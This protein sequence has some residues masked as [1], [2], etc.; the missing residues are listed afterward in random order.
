MKNVRELRTEDKTQWSKTKKDL[1]QLSVMYS[2]YNIQYVCALD[3][4]LNMQIVL[5]NN[6]LVCKLPSTKLLKHL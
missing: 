2:Y 1:L 4:N 3:I 5:H 6:V